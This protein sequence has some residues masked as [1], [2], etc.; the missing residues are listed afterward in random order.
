MTWPGTGGGQVV[1][2]RS[3]PANGHAG[4]YAGSGAFIAANDYGV[5]AWNVGA[6]TSATG[7]AFL[8]WVAP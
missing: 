6:W 1:L 7:Q 2:L 5:Q 3:E 4:I 8:G